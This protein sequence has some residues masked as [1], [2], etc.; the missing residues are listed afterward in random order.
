MIKKESIVLMDDLNKQQM[1][2]R[3]TVND[4]IVQRIAQTATLNVCVW[5]PATL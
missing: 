2:L 1:I 3:D 5:W 4:H